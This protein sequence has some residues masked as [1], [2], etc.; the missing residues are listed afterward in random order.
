MHFA[1]SCHVIFLHLNT[2]EK[3]TVS[4]NLTRK[5]TRMGPKKTVTSAVFQLR[6]PDS[7]SVFY[8]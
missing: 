3:K 2:N 4:A 5:K 1:K 6:T 8:S 7:S